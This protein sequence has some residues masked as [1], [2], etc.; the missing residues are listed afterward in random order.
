MDIVVKRGFNITL[1]VDGVP[2]PLKISAGTQ[3]G[4]L[5]IELEQENGV[6][7]SCGGN[8]A[9]VLQAGDIVALTSYTE[10][11]VT[12][13]KL[14]PFETDYVNTPTLAAG[15]TQVVQEGVPGECRITSLV[16]Y[17]GGAEIS[18]QDQPAVVTL[19]PVSEI[20]NVGTGDGG[21]GTAVDSDSDTFAY[22][23]E[24]TMT[25]TAYTASTCGKSP[26]SKS[27]GITASG[28]PVKYG[29][30]AVDPTVIPLGTKLYIEGYGYALAADTG[31]AIKGMRVDLYMDTLSQALAYG[32]ET[33]KVYVLDGDADN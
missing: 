33:V 4:P 18:R 3:A 16:K 11:T 8:P 17:A 15:V 9:Q 13:T 24:Y 1:V 25:A 21:A 32:R 27:Y 28:L 23:K 31:G 6:E 5:I 14:I 19:E 12:D 20:I 10:Q 29:L 26:S 7:Y 30:V 22:S 2:E